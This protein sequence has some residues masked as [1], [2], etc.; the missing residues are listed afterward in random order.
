MANDQIYWVQP[1]VLS[2]LGS[3]HLERSIGCV[4]AQLLLL[5]QHWRLC[6]T[7]REQKWL[8]VS[9]RLSAAIEASFAATLASLSQDNLFGPEGE[10]TRHRIVQTRAR[11]KAN[12]A[13]PTEWHQEHKLPPD[14]PRSLFWHCCE[15]HLAEFVSYFG[16]CLPLAHLEPTCS[17]AA[18]GIFCCPEVFPWRMQLGQVCSF[19][20][21][22]NCIP[23]HVRQTRLPTNS[24]S[25]SASNDAENSHQPH[26]ITPAPAVSIVFSGCWKC[27]STPSPS[28]FQYLL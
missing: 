15:R 18:A 6:C 26:R 17:E 5:I 21:C 24:F 7:R 27:S 13:V 2:N 1:N 12:P 16:A 11:T 28:L 3:L 20:L 23:H 19:F 14:A 22:I 4:S 10:G 25:L 8:V 9:G